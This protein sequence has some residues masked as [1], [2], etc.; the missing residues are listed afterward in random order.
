MI[1]GLGSHLRARA[2]Q[3]DMF[4]AHLRAQYSDRILYWEKRA[5]SRLHGSAV[6]V[7]ADGMDQMK[8][9]LPRTPSIKSKEFSTFQRVKL[10]VACAI[11]HG[12]FVLF[13]V[14]LPDTKKDS[15]AERREIPAEQISHIEKFL[16]NLRFPLYHM[17]RCADFLEQWIHRALPQEDLLDVSACLGCAW[18]QMVKANKGKDQVNIYLQNARRRIVHVAAARAWSLGVPW[19]QALRISEEAVAAGNASAPV[20]GAFDRRRGPAK[21]KSKGKGKNKGKGRK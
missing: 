3:L 9:S 7:I 14:G 2:A 16:P 10:H 19:A 21:G 11:C 20:P 17:S 1:R 5:M 6:C 18:W 12:R 8:Y 15:L 4:H 13:T